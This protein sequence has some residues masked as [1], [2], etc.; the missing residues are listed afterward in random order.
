MFKLL[1]AAS[2]DICGLYLFHIISLVNPDFKLV[3]NLISSSLDKVTT[4]TCNLQSLIASVAPVGDLFTPGGPESTCTCCKLVITHFLFHFNSK[5]TSQ[6][7]NGMF[8]ALQKLPKYFNGI[9]NSTSCLPTSFASCPAAPAAILY[10][11]PVILFLYLKAF[12]LTTLL[13]KKLLGLL[14]SLNS[15]L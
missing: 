4:G 2:V 5:H 10:V 11:L 12:E 6:L 9:A 14:S 8:I 7:I 3:S 15:S 1:L 13:F